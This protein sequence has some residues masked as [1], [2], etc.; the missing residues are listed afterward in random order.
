ME[1]LK[2]KARVAGLILVLGIGAAAC[3]DNDQPSTPRIEREIE[4]RFSVNDSYQDG[5]RQTEIQNSD[6]AWIGEVYSYC[7]GNDLLDV[8]DAGTGGSTDRTVDH[9]ACNDGKLKPEEFRIPK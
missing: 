8:M 6:D 1:I 2:P 3:G 4:G 5:Q 7:D 9:P